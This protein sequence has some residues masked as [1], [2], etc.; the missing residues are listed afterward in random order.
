MIYFHRSGNGNKNEGAP[1]EKCNPFHRCVRGSVL[2][3][4]P[5]KEA[6]KSFQAPD[7]VF[8]SHLCGLVNHTKHRLGQRGW[9]GGVGM[10]RR[11]SKENQS[12]P[13]ISQCNKLQNLVAWPKTSDRLGS[14]LKHQHGLGGQEDSL[15]TRLAHVAGK[16]VLLLAR[17]SARGLSS[18]HP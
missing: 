14:T 4:H 5:N 11:S 6:V 15:L 9:D 13:M 10:F 2:W 18:W 17:G 16:L 8:V 12:G 3:V 1:R 7:C